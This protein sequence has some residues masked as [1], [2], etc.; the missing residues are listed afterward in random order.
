MSI[1]TSWS[2]FFQ[3]SVR[4]RGRAYQL[5]GRVERI[6]PD[7]DELI[8]AN[9]RGREPYT[10]T[11]SRD[12]RAASAEC[13]CPAFDK[14]AYCKHIWATLL[15][16][17]HNTT[18]P[19]VSAEDLAKLRVRAPKARKRDHSKPMARNS[20]PKW[21]GQLSLMRPPGFDS[22]SNDMVFP[23]Q[24]Q[25]CYAVLPRLSSRH[26][27]LVVDLRQ[28]TPTASGWGK[29]KAMRI[30][31]SGLSSLSDPVD[32][33]LC[34]LLL[35]ANTVHEHDTDESYRVGRGH[36]TFRLPPGAWRTLLTRMIQT[37]RCF[38]EADEHEPG[39]SQK[40]L[41][42][43]GDKPWVLWMTGN[44]VDEE[45]Q[46][47]VE[48]RRGQDRMAIDSPTLLL[49]G[50]DGLVIYQGKVAA[51]D[52]RD[53]FRWASQFRDETK[54]GRE[55]PAPLCVPIKD[56]TNF[57]DRLY[58]LPQLP[59]IDLPEGVARQEQ[60]IKPMATLDLHKPATGSNVGKNQLLARVSFDYAGQK[61]SP[62]QPGR[63]V[64]ITPNAAPD[65]DDTDHDHPTPEASESTLVEADTAP[66]QVDDSTS[67]AEQTETSVA[68]EAPSEV[69]GQPIRRDRAAERRALGQLMTLGLRQANGEAEEL[70]LP[71]KRVVEVVETLISQGWIVNADKR[72]VRQAGAPRLSVSS[73]IDWFELHGSVTYKRADGTAQEVSL[74]QILSM[75][76]AGQ[77]MVELD[78]GTQGL[79]P[80]QWLAEHGLLTGLGKLNDDHLRFQNS[81]AALLD[82]LLSD[83]EQVEVDDR[84]AQARERL[85]HFDGIKSIKSA[86]SFHGKLRP[87][88]EQ[89][90]GWLSF[91]R[92][93]GVGG[94]L[95]DDMGLGKTIQVLAML[96]NRMLT[97]Q[98]KTDSG[99][100]T[101]QDHSD[102]LPH[103]PTLVVAPKSVVFNWLDETAHFAPELKVLAYSGTERQA[104]RADFDDHDL[105]VTSYGLMRR[106]IA[107]LKEHKFDYVVL[108]EA[109][110]IKNPSSQ[111]AKAARLLTTRHRLALTGTPIENHLGDLWSI[112]EFLNPGMLGSSTRF[113]E[114]VRASASVSKTA[115]QDTNAE[116]NGEDEGEVDARP[117]AAMLSQIAQALRPFVL[118]RAK[119]QVLKD[120]PKKTEQTIVC[121]MEPAQRKIYDD[122]RTY[123]HSR[124]LT[125]LD[126]P[127]GEAKRGG[128]SIGGRPAFMVLEALLR[129]RQ[130]ACHPGLID[131]KYADE[132]SAKLDS[133]VEKIADIIDEGSKALVFSQFTSMLSLVK[134]RL[135][136]MGINFCYLDGQ[137]RNRREIVK[138]FQ[139]DKSKSLFLI[140]LKAGGF[141]LNLTAAEYVFILDPWWNPA[142]EAQ[143]IDRTHRIGQTKPVFAYRMVC[144]DTVEQRITE[145]QDRKRRLAEA[146]VGGD[147]SLLR[148]LKREDLEK[149]L[150]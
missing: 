147:D 40:S 77:E 99:D 38:I 3:S 63:F 87:Y 113:N 49:G 114:M 100:G 149:L 73:G 29:P 132:P 136:K 138:E 70:V 133:L 78:D 86:P 83:Q 80:Q 37:G 95:A 140:S 30:S 115:T 43:D 137:T 101:E 15:D 130:A 34:A 81:Q 104:L 45:I 121:Q 109:Q 131:Q 59:E 82:A 112:F 56:V 72:A 69:A 85:R 90:L 127:G 150:S 126:A 84:F 139:D 123:Y 32:R 91:L 55:G 110:A 122:L 60:Q 7:A 1:T 27:G 135:E 106:D 16:L 141:G 53:A 46:V 89:G 35:G 36:A 67:A 93:F 9:V 97:A 17:Q 68:T 108:D 52:D 134:P 25:V 142:V 129:L 65:H 26:G 2:P 57:L 21:V 18:G 124:L 111:S 22:Q 88:Q 10:V 11:I 50:W 44:V 42:W 39:S 79:L 24:R 31:T 117:R 125:Q 107:D 105:I 13:T 66:L 28:R 4:M 128:G 5:G 120:L 58:M 148:S 19:G 47:G 48:L 118:R 12:D 94:V 54:R 75:A 51:L 61:I 96:H 20:E 116:V 144:E 14:G 33:E 6:E 103:R 92:W 143:A 119:S 23:D 62:L 74:P 145:L 64:P 8:R 98:N 71:A 102:V 146:I 76:R 41:T